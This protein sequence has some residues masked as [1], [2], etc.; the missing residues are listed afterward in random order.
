MNSSIDG[1]VSYT[2]L[3]LLLAPTV[4]AIS[5]GLF[6]LRERA[7][8]RTQLENVR[9]SE[10]TLIAYIRAMTRI[11]ANLGAKEYI[12]SSNGLKFEALL[13]RHVTACTDPQCFCG[14]VITELRDAAK[15]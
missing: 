4:I 1:R 7:I 9:R 3:S 5:L 6:I 11:T 15:E 8:E 13:V 2:Y 12:I 10:P 14:E